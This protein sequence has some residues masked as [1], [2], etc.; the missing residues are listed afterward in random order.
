MDSFGHD[1]HFEMKEVPLRSHP[2]TSLEPSSLY[3]TR[4]HSRHSVTL[5]QGI[6]TIDERLNDSMNFAWAEPHA[7][8]PL[9]TSLQC[10]TTYVN[11]SIMPPDQA[12]VH[13]F[14]SF[15]QNNVSSQS[16]NALPVLDQSFNRQRPAQCLTRKRTVKAPTMSA[17]NWKPHKNR[18]RQ[19]YVSEGK[20]IEELREIMNKDLGI[21]A[22]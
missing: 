12:S 4:I 11:G 20:S 21:T 1:M 14:S 9:E 3:T 19:L 13:N 2:Q 10:P 8:F 5:P 16:Q 7:I 17:E 6:P 18:I 22:T 15:R